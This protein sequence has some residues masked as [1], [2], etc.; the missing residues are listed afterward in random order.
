MIYNQKVGLLTIRANRLFSFVLIFSGVRISMKK[1]RYSFKASHSGRGF[2]C[3]A[4][5]SPRPTG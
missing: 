5:A 4:G 3:S 2:K 1:R